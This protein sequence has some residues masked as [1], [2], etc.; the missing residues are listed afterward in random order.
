QDKLNSVLT[1]KAHLNSILN[2]MKFMTSD[3]IKKVNMPIIHIKGTECYIY[4]LSL[5][6]KQVYC[7][8]DVCT[9]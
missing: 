3:I 2:T 1:S 6:D 8:Q 7:V 5:V 9:L 4:S